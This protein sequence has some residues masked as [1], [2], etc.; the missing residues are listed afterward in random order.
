MKTQRQWFLAIIG[1]AALLCNVL[2]FAEPMGTGFTYQGRLIDSGQPANGRGPD[3][4]G[5][6]NVPRDGRPG[7]ATPLHLRSPD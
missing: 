1:V 2:V 6:A 7:L 3:P 5:H 4:F